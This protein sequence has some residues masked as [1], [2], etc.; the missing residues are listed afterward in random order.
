MCTYFCV[1]G[2]VVVVQWLSC[3]WVFATPWTAARQASLSFT[4]SPSLLRLTSI[5]S[6]MPSNHLILCR[7]LLLLPLIFPSIWVFSRVGSAHQ[8]AKVS[9]LQLQHQSFQWIFRVVGI[10]D[11]NVFKQ[12]TFCV[13]VLH[14]FLKTAL[15]I[16]FKSF[17]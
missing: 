1:V 3:V 16:N 2:V 17:C 15:S 14:V 5:E 6:V 11:R 12:Q 7:P 10:D 13:I 4:I 8:V 9:E